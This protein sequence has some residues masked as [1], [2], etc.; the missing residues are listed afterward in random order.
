[1]TRQGEDDAPATPTPDA[2]AGA[3]PGYH[4]GRSP[5]RPPARRPLLARLVPVSERLHGYG[6][7]KLR[8]DLLAGV[9]VAALALPASMAFGELAGLTPVAGLYTL[10]LPA[11]AYAVFGSSRQLIVGPEGSIAAM[12][13]AAVVPLAADD[14]SRAASLASLLALL[15][16]AVYLVARLIRLGWVAD[17]FSQA[18]LLGYLHG[19]AVVLIIGQLGNLVGVTPEAE[20]PLPTLADVLRHLG[21]VLGWDERMGRYADVSVH[22]RA[23]ITPGVLVYRLDDRLFFAN[24]GYVTGRIHE[25]V[26]GNPTPVHWLVFDGE[27][28]SHIDATGAGAL[29]DLIRSFQA[30]GVTFLFARIKTPMRD[31]L[32]DAGIVEL[33]GRDRLY[34][35]VRAAVEAASASSPGSPSEGDGRPPPEAG[36]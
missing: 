29:A 3:G 7:G 18:V 24:A 35:T 14:P 12:V 36:P 8:R 34:P 20:G 10:L 19:V 1:M 4:R 9:T 25:A 13:A 26:N 30:D 22:R 2:G 27:A 32:E 28:L 11:V 5:F 21:D 33:V 23:R 31:T 17:Y 16:G 6:G 15:V